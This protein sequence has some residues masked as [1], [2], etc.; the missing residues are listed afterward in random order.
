MNFLRDLREYDKD[1]IPVSYI[2]FFFFLMWLCQD[3]Y[4]L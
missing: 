2:D 3:V 1:N 4:D